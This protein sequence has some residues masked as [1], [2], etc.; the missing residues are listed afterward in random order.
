MEFTSSKDEFHALFK[1][2]MKLQLQQLSALLGAPY[3][4]IEP[5]SVHNGHIGADALCRRWTLAIKSSD[6][7]ERF[8]QTKPRLVCFGRNRMQMP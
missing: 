1:E 4:P 3:G 6:A 7:F 2:S 8:H 5:T